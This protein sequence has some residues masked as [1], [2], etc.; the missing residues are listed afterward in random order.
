[1][2]GLN[3][4]D[5]FDQRDREERA[6]LLGEFN[7]KQNYADELSDLSSISEASMALDK[8]IVVKNKDPKLQKPG[9]ETKLRDDDIGEKFFSKK[10]RTAKQSTLMA[11]KNYDTTI[12]KLIKDIL[13]K[14]NDE[15]PLNKQPTHYVDLYG[16]E[17]PG[18]ITFQEFKN[19]YETHVHSVDNTDRY[20]NVRD[21]PADNKL[22]A[23]FNVIDPYQRHL[24]SRDEFAAFVRDKQP[25]A[26]F[27][28]RMIQKVKRGKGRLQ[29]ALE[30]ECSEQDTGA[31]SFVAIIPVPIFQAIM[32]DYDMPFVMSDKEHLIKQGLIIED[33]EKNEF[34]KYRDVFD[35]IN[36]REKTTSVAQ[37]AQ[38]AVY[39]QARIRGFL[40]RKQYKF[41]REN[42]MTDLG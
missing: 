7:D 10:E 16:H 18:S 27:I 20:G 25:V 3:M 2:Q 30:A 21:M 41:M 26:N 42:N 33:K 36:P 38:V 14:L 1:M 12:D 6:N 23:V 31:N 19:I 39:I 28:Q 24:I 11:A 13:K 4:G 9:Q 22:K 34:V 37:L 5:I 32:I 17:Y 40:A 35:Y 8:I 15:L 29:V